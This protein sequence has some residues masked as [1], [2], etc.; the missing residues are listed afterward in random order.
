L[1]DCEISRFSAMRM[2]STNDGCD[3]SHRIPL[4]L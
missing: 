2:S 4:A 1:S 3:G